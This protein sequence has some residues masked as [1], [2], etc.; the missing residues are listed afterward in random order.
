MRAMMKRTAAEPRSTIATRSVRGRPFRDAIVA[1]RGLG[2][3]ERAEDLRLDE[4]AEL[5][6]GGRTVREVHERGAT[7]LEGEAI[8][9][10]VHAEHPREEPR[11]RRLGAD[12]RD[13]RVARAFLQ[14]G[15]HRVHVLL[16]QRGLD[17]WRHL[18]EGGGRDLGG[19]AGAGQSAGRE[20]KAG[21]APR[22]EWPLP[23]TDAGRSVADRG[24]VPDEQQLHGRPSGDPRL[25][26]P[27]LELRP[28]LE[29]GGPGFLPA[30]AL[31]LDEVLRDGLRGLGAVD[32]IVQILFDYH[33]ILEI[34]KDVL[35]L[36]GLVDESLAAPARGR[37]RQLGRVAGA[38]D[39][40]ADRVELVR[41]RAPGQ[42]LDRL[43]EALPLGRGHVRKGDVRRRRGRPGEERLDLL[44]DPRIAR[45]V[46]CLVEAGPGPGPVAA[47]PPEHPLPRPML[48]PR[49][50]SQPGMQIGVEDV[51]VPD[52]PE[53][54]AQPV[55]LA[56][57]TLHRLGVEE[58]PARAQDGPELADRD[59][60]LVE[61]LGI[62]ARAGSWLVGTDGL[63]EGRHLVEDVA[64]AWARHGHPPAAR[65]R[66]D[67][68]TGRAFVATTSW[69]R[70]HPVTEYAG[71]RGSCYLL[72][73][74]DRPPAVHR[75]RRSASASA[76]AA[77]KGSVPWP[78]PPCLPVTAS[79]ATSRS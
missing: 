9:V 57:E 47:E 25:L 73:H 76:R 24:G 51:E 69:K 10:L 74:D 8:V 20:A 31:P 5:T 7:L 27:A 60:H 71:P 37:A 12:H 16:T 67:P 18:L 38:L 63:H 55:Q 46:E 2:V 72:G 23:V 58:G 56:P 59:A 1:A 41:A 45:A 4:P 75:R 48:R 49:E 40:D 28:L 6:G 44:Q 32:G 77:R 36:L 11:E 22:G 53:L 43:P 70:H 3:A 61:I 29:E 33:S 62:P 78:M 26:A 13:Q 30:L 39:L 14:R 35:Q 66:A 68:T 50:R 19:G 65:G 42:L 34:S 54:G 79:R 21:A 15:H 52:E 17:A 64:K